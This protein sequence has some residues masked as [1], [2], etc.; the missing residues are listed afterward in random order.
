MAACRFGRFATSFGESP[1]WSFGEAHPKPV[2]DPADGVLPGDLD[3][4][5][6]WPERGEI[7]PGT[8]AR[9]RLQVEGLE[10]LGQRD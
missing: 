3:A 8:E 5:A 4:D 10:L 2:V 1:N 9:R 7:E 6:R